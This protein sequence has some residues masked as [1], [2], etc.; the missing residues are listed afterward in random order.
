[1]A[2]NGGRTILL[3]ILEFTLLASLIW[4][5]KDI[6]Y[7]ATVVFLTTST[8][9]LKILCFPLEKKSLE[10]LRAAALKFVAT[11]LKK[12]KNNLLKLCLAPLCSWTSY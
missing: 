7:H 8:S 3:S 2:Y 11:V 12:Q 4:I 1:M 9:S 6:R 10:L 5:S